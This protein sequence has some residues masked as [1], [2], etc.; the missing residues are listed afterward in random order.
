MDK[1]STGMIATIAA[2]V[3]CGCPG[4]IMCCLGATSVFASQVPGADID[5]MGSSDPA[6]A[7][8][9]GLVFLCLSFIFILIPIA[10]G[11]FTLRKKP[12]TIVS[13]EPLP[14]AS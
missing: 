8:T 9:M 5:V 4:L 7:M 13:D 1:K 6:S 3:L 12:E 10:V 11:F 14:P 2:V